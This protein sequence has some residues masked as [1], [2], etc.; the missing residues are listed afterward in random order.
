MSPEPLP[1]TWAR[2]LT[3]LALFF[4]VMPYIGVAALPSDTQPLAFL[5]CA[6]GV[7]LL[8]ATSRLRV[9]Y[10]ALPLL[11]MVLL[12]TVSLILRGAFDDIEYIWLIR[13]YYGYVSAPVVV[14]FFLHYLRVLRD[15]EIARV[16]DVALVV[17]F[18]GFLLNVSGLTWAIQTVVNRGVFVGV[19]ASARGLPGFFAE[20]SRVSEQMAVF[21][22]CYLL[23]G[24]VTRVRV[25]ALA[26]ASILAAAGQMFIVF[27][28][29]FVAYG[30]ASAAVVFI[31][32][33]LSLRSAT[34]L[35]L[36]G[37]LVVA[38][39]SFHEHIAD[40]LVRLRFPARGITAISSIIE[41]GPAVIGRDQGMMDKLAGTL[42]A[43][44]TIVD[45]PATFRLG[46]TADPDFRQSVERTYA[47]LSRVLL[48]STLL[49]FARRPSTALGL[50]ILEF[51]V[52]GLILALTLIA[53]LLR[54]AA[55]APRETQFYALWAAL[56]LVQVLFIKMTLANPSL[57]LLAAFIWIV[58]SPEKA[59]PHRSQ[60]EAA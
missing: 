60:V 39:L 58:A 8:L 53:L 7:G 6:V 26:L 24:Q 29:I 2:R 41:D 12:A 54:R 1:P 55:R 51:G 9:P 14:L 59:D 30:L 4:S 16:I 40:D 37:V 33:R 18:V 20:Q 36:A 28:H 34:S 10:L 48:D 56:F 5:V 52:A 13:S 45:N 11:A 22:F 21:F 46:A 25:A 15:E 19:Q 27:G 44:A 50:W 3:Q 31:R 17:V 32:E 49:R 47:R 38:L 42:Q 57:W 35:A 43:A 23:A